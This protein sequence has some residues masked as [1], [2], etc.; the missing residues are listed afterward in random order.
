ML[1]SSFRSTTPWSELLSDQRPAAGTKH[2]RRDPRSSIAQ[3][4]VPF[5]SS[6]PPAT[7]MIVWAL[8]YVVVVLAGAV[9]S[10][11]RRNL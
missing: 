11:R 7:P 10:F 2:E 6:T 1:R 3:S 5:F 9:L 8:G 4:A